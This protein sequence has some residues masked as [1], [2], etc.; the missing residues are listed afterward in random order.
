LVVLI[1]VG[2]LVI[3]GERSIQA[4]RESSAAQST[5]S[6]AANETTYQ[7]SYGLFSP[8]AAD[9]RAPA[10]G[11]VNA[12]TNDGEIPASLTVNYDTGATLGGYIFK[13]NA[14][15]TTAALSACN[16]TLNGNT[17]FSFTAESLDGTTKNFCSDQSGTYYSQPTGTAVVPGTTGSCIADL[18]SPIPVGQ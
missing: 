8:T 1:L 7:R 18:T 11:G 5:Q 10:A 3:A 13:Y 2:G 4:A 16:G 14:G 17:S 6:F 12:C 15:G 9:L